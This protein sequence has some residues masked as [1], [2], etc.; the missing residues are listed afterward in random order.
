MSLRI[1]I[2]CSGWSYKHWHDQ[3]YEHRPERD[4]LPRYCELFDTVEVNT[5]FY[6]LPKRP[7]VQSW[8]DRTPDTFTFAV[9]VSRYLTHIKRLTE[10]HDGWQRLRERIEPLIET[11]KLTCLLWQLPGN[12]ERNDAR[13][14]GAIEQLPRDQRHAFEFRHA[15][16]FCPKVMQMLRDAGIALV[17]GDSPDRPFQEHRLTADF[18]Y[19]RF[20]HGHRGRRGNYSP[21][22][23]TLWAE[24]I[25]RWSRQGQ[26]L[27]Y[28]NNDWEAFAVRN[29]VDLRRMV[30]A[31]EFAARHDHAA[32]AAPM[33]DERLV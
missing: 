11:R 2:G 1:Q 5:T 32:A 10:V 27:V 33:I 8:V 29:G 22:E 9:K 12:F 4:W 24:R 20:H 25:Q 19:V 13:L 23:L 18:G 3:V 26:M 7:L 14:A 16:W 15:S 6:R 28:F 30:T 17:I 21:R 31:R